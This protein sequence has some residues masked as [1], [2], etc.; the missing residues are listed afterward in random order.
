MFAPASSAE[1]NA[2]KALLAA[3]VGEPC[4][5]AGASQKL[6][7]KR[8]SAPTISSRLTLTG[9]LIA[10]NATRSFTLLDSAIGPSRGW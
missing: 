9:I 3:G 4:A 8:I 1:C 6:Q 10:S 7:A 5:I 2:S